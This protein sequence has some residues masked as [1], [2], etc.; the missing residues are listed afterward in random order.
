MESSM[1]KEDDD[2]YQ[3]PGPVSSL[4]IPATL[5]DSCVARLD[6][7][8]TAKA[9]TQYAAAIGRQFSYAVLSAGA[10]FDAPTLQRELGRLV[11]AEL[12]Y[13]RGAHP[14][15]PTPSNMP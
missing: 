12:V 14:R 11:E 5:H 6:R 3:L 9:V 1:L 8:V 4:A 2:R 15:R 7:L 10:R 13:Q